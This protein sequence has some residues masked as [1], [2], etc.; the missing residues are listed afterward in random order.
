MK[1]QFVTSSNLASVGYD[2]SSQTLEVEFHNGSV[3]RY[4]NVPET[5]YDGLMH[6]SSSGSFLASQVKDRF[7]YSRVA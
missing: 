4:F 1:R 2:P 3:Y 7:P 5:I 6:A